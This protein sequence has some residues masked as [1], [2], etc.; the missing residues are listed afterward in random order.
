MAVRYVRKHGADLHKI[1]QFRIG[2]IGIDDNGYKWSYC[3]F[4]ENVSSGKVM[5]DMA[6]ADLLSGATGTVTT[7]SPAG[8]DTLIDSG[9]FAG[10]DLVG[11]VGGTLGDLIVNGAGQ[12]FHIVEMIDDDTVR[13]V[14][15]H[16]DL[17]PVFDGTWE[18]ATTGTTTYS[19][20]FPGYVKRSASNLGAIR[21]VVQEDVSDVAKTP[22]G[23]VQQTGLAFVS[24]D[25]DA[26]ALVAGEGILATANGD[27]DGFTGGGTTA[28][29]AAAVIGTCV[30]GD[31]DG[32]ANML[33]L[34]NL[35]ISNDTVSYRFPARGPNYS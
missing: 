4:S 3:W 30:L 15:H 29:E 34:V 16:G 8:T 18:T 28:D 22:Y 21:G 33:T 2:Q 26:G 17:D 7:G 23:W 6:G 27:A 24:I 20:W 1:Q 11:A 13:V 35:K 9:E 25:A 32:T 14:V 12:G 31:V 10:D 19:L 5:V